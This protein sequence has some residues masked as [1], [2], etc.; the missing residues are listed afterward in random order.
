VSRHVS[1]SGR[2]ARSCVRGP[3]G[4]TLIELLV[5]LSII[6]LLVALLLPAL[7][8][9][10]RSARSVRCLANQKQFPIAIGA[11][12]QDWKG[13]LPVSGYNIYGGPGATTSV[14]L[15]GVIAYYSDFKYYTEFGGNAL[16]YPNHATQWLYNP[17][18]PENIL[19]CPDD[20]E[21]NIWSTPTAAY[22][23]ATSYGWNGGAYGLGASD[24]FNEEPYYATIAPIYITLFGRVREQWVKKTST[25]V[26][27]AD[28]RFS[29]GGSRYEYEVYGLSG[30]DR[31]GNW[32]PGDRGNVLWYD[33]HADTRTVETLTKD[34]NGDLYNDYFHREQ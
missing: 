22:Y 11:Y 25:T 17:V 23:S 34:D 10:R 20:P 6:A 16:R 7:T 27:T 21:I 14:I 15:S 33:G 24:G 19:T 5:V 12:V 30:P 3:L 18:K 13:F 1:P 29:P 32:H 9:A 2:P 8:T 28:F 4:F 26:M 31:L